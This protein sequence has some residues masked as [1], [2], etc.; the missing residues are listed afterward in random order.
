MSR[1]INYKKP[2]DTSKS[3]QSNFPLGE[4]RSFRAEIQN[5]AGVVVSRETKEVYIP[6]LTGAPNQSIEMTILWKHQSERYMDQAGVQPEARFTVAEDFMQGRAL[7]CFRRLRDNPN[8]PY[9][10]AVAANRTL[11]QYHRLL[12]DMHCDLFDETYCGNKVKQEVTK[13]K[14]DDYRSDPNQALSD[15][16]VDQQHRLDE[17]KEMTEQHMH[18]R[19]AVWDDAFMIDLLRKRVP[20]SE[21]DWLGETGFD[22]FDGNHTALQVAEKLD[23]KHKQAIKEAAKKQK[24]RKQK[25]EKLDND[26]EKE[27]NKRANADVDNRSNKRRCL[28]SDRDDDSDA[29]NES[30]SGNDQ[31]SSGDERSSDDEILSDDDGSR[32]DDGSKVESDDDSYSS[33]RRD[34]TATT[35]APAHGDSRVVL[36][37]G[38]DCTW[39]N[40]LVNPESNKFDWEAAKQYRAGSVVH[41]AAAAVALSGASS[42]TAVSPVLSAGASSLPSAVHAVAQPIART[43]LAACSS[44]AVRPVPLSGIP[45]RS[46]S[47]SSSAL[48]WPIA[49]WPSFLIDGA[50]FASATS[51]VSRQRPVFSPFISIITIIS[52]QPNPVRTTSSPHPAFLSTD[53]ACFRFSDQ[54]DVST[55]RVLDAPL[56]FVPHDRLVPDDLLGKPPSQLSLRHCASTAES[57]AFSMGRAESS[58]SIPQFCTDSVLDNLAW[59]PFH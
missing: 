19:G 57:L 11:A 12:K 48:W 21:W 27:E 1:L 55:G 44:S 36:L 46:S 14:I 52:F 4:K 54:P 41:Q 43:G 50:C 5:P 13:W 53:G 32:E 15:L 35:Q 37:N 45:L 38:M 34:S 28:H 2:W 6:I 31:S 51:T 47:G 17:I 49:I 26:G 24:R 39:K 58:D 23:H 9:M 7:S 8:G 25:N 33:D 29:I 16:Y 59:D 18:H 30:S 20:E 3:L 42:R 22:P 10:P 56:S 40:C